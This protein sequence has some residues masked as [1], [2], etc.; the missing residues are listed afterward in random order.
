[1]SEYD[2]FVNWEVLQKNSESFNS[3]KPFRYAFVKGFFKTDFYEKLYNSFPKID[4]TWFKNNDYRRSAKTLYFQ[5]KDEH[6]DPK[7]IPSISKEWNL[8]KEIINS[9]EFI[10]KFSAFSGIPFSNIYQ[11]GFFANTKGDF[12]LPH[13][14]EE[15]EYQFKLQI[16]FYFSKNWQENDPGGTYLCTEEDESSRFFEPYDL[17]NTFVCFEE[18]PSSWHG[19]RYITKDNV[20]RQ[21]LAVSLV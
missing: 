8:V 9:K 2:D 19:T 15:G 5:E 17:D 10:E 3:A 14:D 16:M 4:D 12:Q 6:K 13:I 7:P 20:I 11:S 1:M 21:A 18:T